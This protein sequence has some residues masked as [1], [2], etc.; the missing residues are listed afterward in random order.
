MTLYNPS[1]NVYATKT[2]P[3]TFEKL[4]EY[5]HESL[6]FGIPVSDLIYRDA[7]P[8]LTQDVNFAAVIGKTYI[9]GVKCDHLLFGRPGVDFQVWVAEGSKPLPLKYVVTDRATPSLM[10]F[11]AVM[12]G[13]NVEPDVKD[14]QFTFVPPKGAQAINFMPF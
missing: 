11:S 3:D 12:S 13:W 5:I 4:F 14:R 6:G 7:Y 9:N 1:E 8:L 2:A 10:S